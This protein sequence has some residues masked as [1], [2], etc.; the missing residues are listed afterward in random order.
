MTQH[1]GPDPSSLCSL[2]TRPL[3]LTGILRDILTRQFVSAN[4]IE[5]PS[6]KHLLWKDSEDSGILIESFHRWTPAMTSSRPGIIIKRDACQNSRRG[7][8]DRR[9][10]GATGF[11]HYATFW[12]GSHTLFCLGNHGA[13]TEILACE[14]QRHLTQFSDVIARTLNLKRFQVLQVGAVSLLEESSQNFVVPV[15]IGYTYEESWVVRPQV[16]TLSAVSL[17]MLLEQ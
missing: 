7:V 1:I 16:P 4:Y 10:P 15:T 2:L 6:L 14:V 9:G 5:E 13:E 3:I 12:T 8:G 11:D 17:S